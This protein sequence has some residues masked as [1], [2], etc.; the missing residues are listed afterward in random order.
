MCGKA[1]VLPDLTSTFSYWRKQKDDA[2]KSGD[3]DTLSL[4]LNHMN[5]ALELDY[6]VPTDDDLWKGQKDDYIVWKC[7]SCTTTEKKTINKG[8]DN[9]YIKE[10]EVPTCSELHEIK[11]FEENC[12]DIVAFLTESK[13][14]KMWE[15]PKCNHVSSVKS[16]E[17]QLR[18]YPRPH[19]RVCIYTEPE[20]PLTGLMRRRG[21]YPKL[22]RVWGRNYSLE[23]ERQ[24]AVYRI[25]YIKQNGHD[26]EDSGYKDKG[27]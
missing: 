14:R 3:W 2:L 7:N 24:L 5:G 9:E 22:M 27:D 18:K 1:G 25:E 12:S 15:C 4:S 10:V 23:L 26:M 13:T 21:S 20:R 8:E 11:I 6:R 17:T 16:R 19:Y